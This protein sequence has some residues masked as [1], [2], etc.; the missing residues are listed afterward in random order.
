VKTTIV[1]QEWNDVVFQWLLQLCSS[2]NLTVIFG[3]LGSSITND[4]AIDCLLTNKI[5]SLFSLHNTIYDLENC[6]IL[7]DITIRCQ[8]VH[9]IGS[10]TTIFINLLII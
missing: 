7:A 2:V 5:F 1:V 6:L 8:L 3:L 4:D 10:S 9:I